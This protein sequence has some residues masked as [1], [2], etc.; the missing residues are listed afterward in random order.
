MRSTSLSADRRHCLCQETIPNRVASTSPS[1]L[2][3]TGRLGLVGRWLSASLVCWAFALP[4]YSQLTVEIKDHRDRPVDDAVVLVFLAQGNGGVSGVG[5]PIGVMDQVDESFAPNVLIVPRGQSVEFP[6][7]DDVRH[8]VYSFSDAKKF[9]LPLYEGK[10]ANPVIFDASGPVVLGCNIH[11]WMRGYI[12]VTEAPF[13]A[14]SKEG[15]AEFAGLPAGDYQVKVWHPRIRSKEN[16]SGSVTLDG[17]GTGTLNVE[18]RLK[19]AIKIRR[20]PKAGAKKY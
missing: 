3:R 2:A 12:Y 8:H 18:I 16:W 10:P 20:A 4:A 7:Y 9:E 1:V 15:A 17:A 19:P 5:K 6:N 14:L 11:D 13:S